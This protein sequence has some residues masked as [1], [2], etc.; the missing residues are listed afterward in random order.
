MKTESRSLFTW[1]LKNN[2][3][4][5]KYESDL[6]PSFH[7]SGTESVRLPTEEEKAKFVQDYERYDAH[8]AVPEYLKG[9]KEAKSVVVFTYKLDYPLPLFTTWIE[10]L[11]LKGFRNKWPLVCLVSSQRKSFLISF[12]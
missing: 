1:D 11:I 4:S 2:T 8:G 3:G 10:D 9:R 5:W 12:S 7:F 6:Y